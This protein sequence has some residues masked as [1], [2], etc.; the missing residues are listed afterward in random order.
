MIDLQALIVSQTYYQDKYCAFLYNLKRGGDGDLYWTIDH[1]FLGESCN[2]T[3]MGGELMFLAPLDVVVEACRQ[4]PYIT[5][6]RDCF[7]STIYMYQESD[8]LLM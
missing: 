4:H 3:F 1:Y 6:V 2:V 5:V 8:L 7:F